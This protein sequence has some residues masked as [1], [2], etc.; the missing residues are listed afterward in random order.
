MVGECNWC[1]NEWEIFVLFGWCVSRLSISKQCCWKCLAMIFLVI[2]RM[3]TVAYSGWAPMN[4]ILFS[5]F[6]S[7]CQNI[8]MFFHL[9]FLIQ[10][11]FYFLDWY[12]FFK[13][14]FIIF[15]QFCHIIWFQL[16]FFLIKFAGPYFF[17]CCLFFIFYI[18]FDLYFDRYF[19]SLFFLGLSQ[20]CAHSRGVTGWIQVD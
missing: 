7:L 2:W 4:F 3:Y 20:S 13:Y 19:F 5:L 16:S 11:G 8:N 9:F 17:N 6:S 15:F 18:K 10:F 1:I 14:F 12:L